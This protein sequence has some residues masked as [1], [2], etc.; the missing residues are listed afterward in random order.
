MTDI[1]KAV[2]DFAQAVGCTTDQ[3]NERQT[4][5]YTGLQAEEF[6]EKIAAI[7][8][9]RAV[10][11]TEITAL[12]R[13]LHLRDVLDDVSQGMAACGQIVKSAA[14]AMNCSDVAA[15]TA[16]ANKAG[17]GM[18]AICF[19]AAVVEMTEPSNVK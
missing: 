19:L 3:F 14:N 12:M 13:L 2:R 1:I 11:N 5:L 8:G 10:P 15:A 9:T 7:I 6:S 17:G 16:L 4:A 18:T